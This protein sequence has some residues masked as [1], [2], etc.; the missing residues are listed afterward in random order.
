MTRALRTLCTSCPITIL[1]SAPL[2]HFLQFPPADS[3]TLSSGPT[4]STSSPPLLPSF[5]VLCLNSFSLHLQFSK[6]NTSP[7]T[8]ADFSP[9]L[10]ALPFLLLPS[11]YPIDRFQIPSA[12]F[13]PHFKLWNQ[14]KIHLKYFTQNSSHKTPDEFSL[15]RQQLPIYGSQNIL[16]FP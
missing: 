6:V 11:I 2:S 3:Y 7:F 10:A 9:Y 13:P 4:N 16:I 14:L 8:W 12:S 15:P 5:P 1:I